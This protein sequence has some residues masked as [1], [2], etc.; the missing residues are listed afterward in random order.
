MEGIIALIICGGIF[1]TRGTWALT[2]GLGILIVVLSIFYT[3]T[4][5]HVYL[6]W[7]WSG[8]LAFTMIV[9]IANMIALAR[10]PSGA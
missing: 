4:P 10:R 8:L 9:W 6:G 5:L 7:P 1:Y 3:Y 2:R